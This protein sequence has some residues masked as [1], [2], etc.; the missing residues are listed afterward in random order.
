MASDI[1]PPI[2]PVLSSWWCGLLELC[3]YMSNVFQY[4]W[5]I[6]GKIFWKLCVCVYLCVYVYVCVHMFVC[7]QKKD[8]LFS[9]L[10][11]I[12]QS[13][14]NSFVFGLAFLHWKTFGGGEAAYWGVHKLIIFKMS[15]IQKGCKSFQEE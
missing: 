4:L 7:V 1:L 15:P 6:S 5:C 13:N 8:S 12:T 11:Y 10:P 9:R 3:K 2:N 14:C